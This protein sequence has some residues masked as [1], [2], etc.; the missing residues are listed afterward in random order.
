MK[1]P[2]TLEVSLFTHKTIAAF[3]PKQCARDIA[4]F[5]F[6]QT[7]EMN[8]ILADLLC[9]QAKYVEAEKIAMQVLRQCEDVYARK[10]EKLCYAA[11]VL[12]RSCH[13]QG[14]LEEALEA[15]KMASESNARIRS[16]DYAVIQECE[17][18]IRDITREM[19]KLRKPGNEDFP[20]MNS[21]QRGLN[22]VAGHVDS[23]LGLWSNNTIS[24][25]PNSGP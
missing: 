6:T 2:C 14:R 9:K 23:V 13:A 19:D 20:R 10:H 16:P 24:T 22:E 17:G 1:I 25:F 18:R 8:A 15:T 4:D 21:P 5:P 7:L 11:T 12:R 3:L